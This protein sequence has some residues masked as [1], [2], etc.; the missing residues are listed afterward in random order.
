MAR[1]VGSGKEIVYGFGAYRL[2]TGSKSLKSGDS[3]LSVGDRGYRLLSLMV[4]RNGEVVSKAELLEAAGQTL[5][6]TNA[7]SKFR[8]TISDA[9]YPT[10]A[11]RLRTSPRCAVEVIGSYIPSR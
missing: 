3:T 1:G 5:V 4:Q 6:V 2:H 11:N 8:S 7:T 9:C 10:R